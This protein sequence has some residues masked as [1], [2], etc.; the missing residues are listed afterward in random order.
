MNADVADAS[1]EHENPLPTA[2]RGRSW[3]VWLLMVAVFAAG[4]GIGAGG[5]LLFARNQLVALIQHP[6]LAMPEMARLLG[7]RLS[8]TPDQVRRVEE[9]LVARQRQ[10]DAIRRQMS[11]QISAELNKI[12]EEVGAVLDPQQRAQWHKL[13]NRLRRT[14]A[15]PALQHKV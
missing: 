7:R 9:I 15:P 1:P 11:P 13:F 6:E 5:A 3:L 8:L 14:W 10:M 2:P 4:L 12:D